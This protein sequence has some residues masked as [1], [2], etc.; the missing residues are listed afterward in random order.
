MFIITLDIF[1]GQF[2]SIP[3]LPPGGHKSLDAEKR[4]QIKLIVCSPNSGCRVL[5]SQALSLG[6]KSPGL[7]H[8]WEYHGLWVQSVKRKRVVG[9]MMPA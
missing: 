3:I 9:K 2:F 5:W 7:G 6:L 1:S 4:V 8:N